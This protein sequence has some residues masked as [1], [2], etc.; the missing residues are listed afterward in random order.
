MMSAMDFYVA[1]KTAPGRSTRTTD[2]PASAIPIAM[3][4]PI[5]LA[6]P[7]TSATLFSREKSTLIYLNPFLLRS[8]FCEDINA[9]TFAGICS[10]FT[11]SSFTLTSC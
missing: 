7:V 9:W 1:E 2:A 11:A 10:N 8:G 3:A 4:A 5:P 6:A